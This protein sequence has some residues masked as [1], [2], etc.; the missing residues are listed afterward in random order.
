MLL[1]AF[2]R[3]FKQGVLD[4]P[5]VPMRLRESDRPADA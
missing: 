4:P 5:T 3:P 1:A 2:D